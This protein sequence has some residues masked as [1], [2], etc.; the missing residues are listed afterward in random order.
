V[1]IVVALATVVLLTV[2]S[3][4]TRAA[5][6]PADPN[7]HLVFSSDARDPGEVYI[8][9]VSGDAATRLTAGRAKEFDPDLSPRGTRIAYGRNPN[10]RS[11]E[12][13]SG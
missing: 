1:R 11:D 6:P 10:G 8:P 5:G 12:P 3:A 13:T 7:G 9:G 2:P 4:A